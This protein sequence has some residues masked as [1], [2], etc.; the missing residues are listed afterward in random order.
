V[1]EQAHLVPGGDQCG[2]DVRPD[3][4]RASDDEDLHDSKF[5]Q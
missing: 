3:V 1:L 2:D 5:F 4:A